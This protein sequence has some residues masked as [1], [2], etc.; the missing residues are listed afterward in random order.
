MHS[1]PLPAH[2]SR[3]EALLDSALAILTLIRHYTPT[4]PV[5]TFRTAEVLQAL[6]R[7]APVPALP[8]IPDTMTSIPTPS[9]LLTP[10]STP[11]TYAE[12]TTGTAPDP[13]VTVKADKPTPTNP[14]VTVTAD[15][16]TPT[17]PQAKARTPDLILRFDHLYTEHDIRVANRLHPAHLFYHIEVKTILDDLKLASI[18]W[19][20]RG[21]LT[22][23]FVRNEQ[24]S[25]AEV[26]KRILHIWNYLRPALE[27][28]EDCPPVTIDYGGSWHNI[29][30]HS[31]PVPH[32]T[33]N[34]G[35]PII[36]T[37]RVTSWLRSCGITGAIKATSFMCSDDDLAT[38]DNAPLH[39]SLSSQKDADMLVHNGALVLGSHC[40]VSRYVPKTSSK[41]H[42]AHTE[43]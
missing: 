3:L 20:P 6:C 10:T 27:L 36:P 5:L 11:A 32:A 28:S 23:A 34:D 43:L 19:T 42:I 8:S 35:T 25:M 17:H 12:A 18:H 37:D 13:V 14:V 22:F 39:V 41:P 16:P 24:F 4:G 38:R 9:S 1:D 7:H 21:N 33:L 30:I 31:V 26:R 15:K 2:Y 40:R 29:V